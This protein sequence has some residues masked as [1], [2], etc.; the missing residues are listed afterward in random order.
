MNGF[1]AC[2]LFPW[3]VNN[4]DFKKCLGKNP[5]TEK[6]NT[7]GVINNETNTRTLDYNQFTDIVGPET[8]EKFRNIKD[9]ITSE[10]HSEEFFVLYRLYEMFNKNDDTINNV[11]YDSNHFLS[12]NNM[13]SSHE[14]INITTN[15]S[16]PPKKSKNDNTPI[17]NSELAKITN[18]LVDVK[19]L[20]ISPI[21]SVLV[22]PITPERKG[23][24]ITERV[25]F[26]ISSQ[27]WQTLS[28]E[29]EKKKRT[30]EEERDCKKKKRL[31]NIQL[32]KSKEPKKNVKKSNIVRNMF[33]ASTSKTTQPETLFTSEKLA[34]PLTTTEFLDYE[35]NAPDNAVENINTFNSKSGVFLKNE[36]LCFKCAKNLNGI[37]NGLECTFCIK[38]YHLKCLDP[39]EYCC[40]ESNEIL[41][42]CN[43]CQKDANI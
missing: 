15:Q 40:L 16:Q 9:M 33:Q 34:Q 39:K 20:S 5:S 43:E 4:I 36:G 11:S 13:P 26:V 38:L 18:N 24:R 7:I 19:H 17:N 12:E 37:D 28:E 29:K 30:V 32:K 1:K 23:T 6:T 2:G 25:P 22:W 42:I 27:K 41:Y 8:I 10:S 21:E 3:D 14:V 35:D 31:E